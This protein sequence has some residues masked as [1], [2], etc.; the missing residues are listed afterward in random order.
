[1]VMAPPDS[2]L[3][4]APRQLCD[5]PALRMRLAGRWALLFSHPDDFAQEQLEMDRWVSVVSRS[6]VDLG[7]LP[8]ALA[9]PGAHPEPGWLDRVA[10]LDAGSTAVLM[11]DPPAPG[12]VADFAANALRAEIARSGPRFAMI[13]DSKLRC[14]R[15]LS[16][17]LRAGLPSP[18]DLIGWA[19]ALRRRDGSAAGAAMPLYRSRSSARSTAALGVLPSR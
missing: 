7:L 15:L 3:H 2:R 6:F 11:L 1:M 16:Y 10:A 9:R 19:A 14:R 5:A 13:I 4:V 8:V 17:R 12:T 18:L